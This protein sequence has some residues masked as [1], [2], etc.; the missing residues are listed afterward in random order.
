M[1]ENLLI[2]DKAVMDGEGMD[3]MAQGN[4]N[5]QT[6]D[7]DLTFFIV[8]FKT[9]DKIIN[10]MPLVG[11]IIGGKK[12][13]I[14]TYPVKVTGN[15][16][17]PQLSVLS[18]TAIGKAAVDF[19]FDTLTL[20]LDLLPMPDTAQPEEQNS[21]KELKTEKPEQDAPGK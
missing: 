9:I 8:P 20:P 1:A 15:L 11:R 17:D 3:I 14:V 4:I 21:G 2:L 10:M 18:P 5:L 7:T 16:R 19:I 13:H 6:L 12:R